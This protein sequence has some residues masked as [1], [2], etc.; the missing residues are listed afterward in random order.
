MTDP[1][2]IN[3]GVPEKT[4]ALA[5]FRRQLG[6]RTEAGADPDLAAGFFM[7]DRRD[8]L[9]GLLAAA[10]NDPAGEGWRVVALMVVGLE[11]AWFSAGA[12][13]QLFEGDINLE[14]LNAAQRTQVFQEMV[15]GLMD[16]WA[17]DAG[18]G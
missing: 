1:M 6:L 17:A 5:E 11:H 13:S 14:G 10:V 15:D 7:G 16:H 2:N 8:T 9:S 4:W 3:I 18:P 12:V